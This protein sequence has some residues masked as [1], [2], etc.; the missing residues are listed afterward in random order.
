MAWGAVL[1]CSVAKHDVAG[2]R[3]LGRDLGRLEIAD[4]ADEDD[5]G[6]LAQQ[7]AQHRGELQVDVRC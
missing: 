5:V 1:V 7:R 2:E 4:L 6:I 3:G